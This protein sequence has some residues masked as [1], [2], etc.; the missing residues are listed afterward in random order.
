MI[1]IDELITQPWVISN[2]VIQRHVR[3]YASLHN[4]NVGDYPLLSSAPPV[5]A[6]STRVEKLEKLESTHTWKLTLRSLERLSETNRIKT[7][8]WTEE[9]DAVVIATGPYVSPH[10]PNI[11]GLVDWSQ[12]KDAGRFSVYHSQSY[13]RPERYENKVFIPVSVELC[14]RLMC[15]RLKTVLIVGAS[16]SA[17]EIARDI[18]PYAKTI[19]ASIR[20]SVLLHVYS[21]STIYI[22]Q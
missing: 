20:V 7:Q 19:L 22:C 8:W 6:Y 9:F 2:H 3:A 5:T 11:K 10:V 4:L 15:S 1:L 21:V 14:L 12:V 13:R 17:S 16:V 18:S